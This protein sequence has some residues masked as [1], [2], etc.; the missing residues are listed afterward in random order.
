MAR[1]EFST[2]PTNLNNTG[3]LASNWTA[4]L[5]SFPP[6]ST[7]TVV[8]T[9]TVISTVTTYLFR[10]YFSSSGQFEYWSGASRSTPPP[11]GHVLLDVTVIGQFTT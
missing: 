3:V 9:T 7:S 6:V 1:N 5:T 4:P 11:T 2:L 10:G 8:T